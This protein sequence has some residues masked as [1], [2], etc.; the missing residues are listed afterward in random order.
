MERIH[1]FMTKHDTVIKST[2][3]SVTFR[4]RADM[5]A[6]Q[7][8][9]LKPTISCPYLEIQYAKL[10]CLSHKFSSHKALIMSKPDL[11]F[12]Q[13]LWQSP[14]ATERHLLPQ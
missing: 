11:V 6:A 13:H 8:S 3:F 4:L 2:G 1:F 5:M 12:I 14:R 9:S 7:S 10:P